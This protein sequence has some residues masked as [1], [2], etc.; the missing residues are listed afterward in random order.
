MPQSLGRRRPRIAVLPL[1]MAG[2]VFAIGAAGFLA[3]FYSPDYTRPLLPLPDVAWALEPNGLQQAPPVAVFDAPPQSLVPL[4]SPAGDQPP[5]VSP[6]VRSS[7]V[8]AAS[9]APVVALP[10]P[11][12]PTAAPSAAAESTPTRYPDAPGRAGIAL[13]RDS[14]LSLLPSAPVPTGSTPAASLPTQN[15]TPPATV[16]AAATPSPAVT[17]A[18][19]RQS[20][21]EGGEGT[22][23]KDNSERRGSDK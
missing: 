9:A 5:T 12:S 7:V 10:P 16:P 11:P 2:A 22:N 13:P 6:P 14:A 20:P 4:D 18:K 23:K 19:G 1:T 3:T 21:G 8:V 15:A 17:T